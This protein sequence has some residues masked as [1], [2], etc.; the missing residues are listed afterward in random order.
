M[1]SLKIKIDEPVVLYCE[2]ETDLP[3]GITYGP[4]VRDIYVFESCI[5]G[6]GAVVI[7]G[8]EYPVRAGDCYILMPGDTIIHKADDIY[9]RQ[10]IWCTVGGVAVGRYLKKAG[11]T[12]STPFASADAFS[13]LYACLERMHSL[14]VSPNAG[15]N[16]ML[17]GC[18]YEF[19][20]I[21]FRYKKVQSS[22]DEWIDKA[23]GIIE[24]RYN[25]HLT[26]NELAEET[27]L[28]RAYFSTL[29]K[30]KLGLSPH[31]YITSFKLKKACVLLED[32]SASV[33][34]VAE[35]VGIPQE[36]FA[37]VFKNE[38]GITPLAYRKIH[39]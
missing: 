11:I 4:V 3:P 32:T 25:E 34:N 22:G 7:N 9:P 24:S 33:G 35:S 16:L 18:V 1:H 19:L 20:S 26:V 17:T 36:N 38:F 13:E 6:A 30:D 31:E 28:E 39:K 23:L 37:R 8:R 29:F 21:L 2:K 12:T 10:G 27:G 14:W 5:R 15:T